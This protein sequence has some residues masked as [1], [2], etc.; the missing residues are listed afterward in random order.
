MDA[1]LLVQHA[2][3]LNAQGVHALKVGSSAAA[4]QLFREA[5]EVM[6]QAP[7][8]MPPSQPYH[9]YPKIIVSSCDVPG[10][11]RSDYYVCNAPLLFD[12]TDLRCLDGDALAICCQATMFNLA[13]TAHQRGM[14]TG[15]QGNLA[16][17]GRLYEQCLRLNNDIEGPEDEVSA[18]VLA[19]LNNVA[20][21]FYSP[22]N[23]DL[24]LER[25]QCVQQLVSEAGLSACQSGLTTQL[26]EILLN[27]LA[28]CKPST[29][30]CA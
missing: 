2:S 6:A 24:A 27:V 21:I 3:L 25:L 7:P 5:L 9:G 1:K 12:V 14:M 19:S 30:P 17:A 10:F 11:D 26:D 29:A 18:V 20:Q 8:I 23:Y 15:F 28:M 22:G 13:L 16:S 4:H